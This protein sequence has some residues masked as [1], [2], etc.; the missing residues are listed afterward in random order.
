MQTRTQVFRSHSSIT[1]GAYAL[2]L[3]VTVTI[4]HFFK[5]AQPALLYLVPFC[6]GSALITADAQ[7]SLAA[8]FEYNEEEEEEK[9]GGAEA[10]SGAAEIAE[11]KDK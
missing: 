8:L 6:L 7:G 10:S 4:M 3:I 9:E 11:K 5:A 2:G 1:T